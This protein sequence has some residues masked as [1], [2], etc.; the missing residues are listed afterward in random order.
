MI[1]SAAGS[2]NSRHRSST[3][4]GAALLSAVLL[5]SPF[6]LQATFS[7]NQDWRLAFVHN[8]T[9]YPEGASIYAFLYP[10]RTDHLYAAPF[11]YP[12]NV[13]LYGPLFYIAGASIAWLVGAPGSHGFQA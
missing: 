10:L 2:S 3:W 1:P 5:L 6:V 9:T 7:L 13:Q 8:D 12:W 4:F 11:Q